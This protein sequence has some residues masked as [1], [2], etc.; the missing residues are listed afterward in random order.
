MSLELLERRR[1]LMSI[2]SGE[3]E[4]DYSS[5]Y[6]TIESVDTAGGV[7]ITS[8][9]DIPLS[10]RVNG[11]SWIDLDFSN[12]NYITVTFNVGDILE[13]V[14]TGRLS[15]GTTSS[16]LSFE[17][18]NGGTPDGAKFLIYGNILSL[19]YGHNF[20]SHTTIDSSYTYNFQRM[21]WQVNMV[22]DASNLILP[23]N[24]TKYL[25]S[26][27][28][29]DTYLIAA[30]KLP[31]TVLEERCYNQMFYKCAYLTTAPDLP[32][33]TLATRCYQSMFRYCTRLNYVKAMFTTTPGSTYTNYW[34]GGVASNGTFVK[35]RN[36]TWNVSGYSGIPSHWTVVQE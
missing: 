11:G 12:N 20:A 24:T 33:L 15:N 27:M 32:A 29:Q 23:T 9:L 28:F 36:A 25:Y 2:H 17:F 30:P 7:D 1:R 19:T 10:Y 35:N 34:L 16:Y 6:F 18:T 5:K 13:F 3:P 14:C 21:F 22:F 8:E 31:A 4:V 26:S